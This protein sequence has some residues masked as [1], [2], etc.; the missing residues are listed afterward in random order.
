ML[1]ALY[2]AIRGDVPAQSIEL[3]GITYTTA[4]VC[5]VK[6]PEPQRITVK[7]LSSLVDYLKV[8]VDNL[9]I[10]N[11]I[12]HIESPHRVSIYSGLFGSFEQRK[13]YISAELDQ[14]QHKFNTYLDG[15]TFNISLQSMFIDYPDDELMATDRGLVLAYCSNVREVGEGVT[16]DDGI[17]QAVTVKRGIAAVENV[18]LPNPVILRPYRTFTEVVQPAS[19]FVFR[20]KEGPQFMLVEADGGAWKGQAMKN[21]KEYMEF[22]VPKLAVIA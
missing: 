4:P 13:Y 18:V 10:P 2:E 14:L 12:C 19:S 1:K 11:L 20:A 7:N 22:E 8:N 6:S 16:L 15:E 3:G 5:P 9:D 17:T 21:I